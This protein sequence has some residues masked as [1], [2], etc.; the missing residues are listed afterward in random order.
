MAKRWRM[1]HGYTHS[2]AAQEAEAVGEMPLTRAVEFLYAQ[3]ECKKHKVSRRRVR[4][5]LEENCAAGWHHIAGPNGVRDVRYFSTSLTDDQKRILLGVAE[6][7]RD[8]P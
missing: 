6:V 5:F 1:V 3:L 7:A 4:Q 2:R 8:T